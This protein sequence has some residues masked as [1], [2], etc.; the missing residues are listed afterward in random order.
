MRSGL[1][2][3]SSFVGIVMW[4][5]DL[6]NH[7]DLLEIDPDWLLGVARETLEREQV[8]VAELVIAIVDDPAIH[9]VNREHLQHDYPTDVISFLYS[10]DESGRDL[11][12]LGTAPR[13]QGLVLDGELVI[14][15]E[16]A[17]RLAGEH[18]LRPEQELA[19]YLVHGLLHLCGYDD[20]TPDEREKMRERE[21]QILAIWDIVPQVDA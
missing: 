16:T 4:E 18:H 3:L 6:V 2:D 19:L 11:K 8:D 12:S 1:F 7:Q 5:I 9:D 15:A 10:V 17:I 21:Q 13:G 14:S 20:L